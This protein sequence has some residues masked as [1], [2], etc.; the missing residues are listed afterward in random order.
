MAAGTETP[1]DLEVALMKK[2]ILEEMNTPLPPIE[3]DTLTITRESL[4]RLVA[5]FQNEEEWNTDGA[6]SN[7]AVFV[8]EMWLRHFDRPAPAPGTLGSL[9][10]TEWLTS[11]SVGSGRMPLDAYMTSRNP[12]RV[13]I[14]HR[15]RKKRG[16]HKDNIT[17]F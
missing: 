14:R 7:S 11:Y 6:P 5:H 10:V 12:A 4:R 13:E 3:G 2:Q 1:A 17:S 16:K 15:E 8:L 9:Y